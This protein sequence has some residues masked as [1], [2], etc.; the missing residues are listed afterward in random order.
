[1]IGRK[2]SALVFGVAFAV[3][4]IHL[5]QMREAP[6]FSVLMGDARGYDEWAQMIAGGQWLGTD[7]FYQAPL[8]PY[9]LG[10]IYAV[11]GRDLTLVRVI[12]AAVGAA[13]CTMLGLAASRL[14][15]RRVGLVAGLSLALYA[16]AIFFDALIQKTVLD[17][18]FLCLVL[19][20]SSRL[21]DS[22]AG[23]REWAWLGI[24]LG[25]FALTRE[26]ALVLAI[27]ILAW[28]WV[29]S[30]PV[31]A[32][33]RIA[34]AGAFALGL[35][36]VLAPVVARNYAVGGGFYVTTAQFGPN[37][38]IGN[39]ARADG[40]YAPLRPG[41]GAPEYERRDATDL[42]ERALGRALTPAQVS[43]YWT[44]RA[45]AFISSQPGRWVL[46]LGRKLFLLVNADEML[47]TESQETHAESSIVLRV[48][49]WFGHFG[50]LVPLALVGAVATWPER[51]R[52]W[53]VHAMA[54]AY[55]AS[56]IAFYVF[57]RYRFPLVPF[58][59]LFASAGLLAAPSLILATTLRQRA[60]LA[61][62]I[63][64]AAIVANWPALSS[65]M[66]R[67]ITETNLAAAL[68]ENG[69]IDEALVH[70]R[71]A[72]AIESGYAP[73]Y[74]NLG[75]ALRASGRVGEAIDAYE[76]SLQKL[77]DYPDAHYNLANALLEQGRSDEAAAHLRI[78]SRSLPTSAGVHN[79]LGKALAD[80]GWLEEAA[81]ELRQAVALE[82]GSATAHHNLGNVLA[83]QGQIEE[84]FTQLRRAME[85]EPAN[86]ETGYDLGTL[87]LEAGRIEEAVA[88]FEAVLRLRPLYAEAHNNLGIALASQG[89]VDQAMLHFERAVEINPQLAD[90]RRNLEMARRTR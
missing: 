56:V 70:Y 85:L 77:P 15:S 30:S 9:F 31:H 16:P 39:N 59:V 7:V 52:L 11:L 78:A 65:A 82:P 68:Q 41:R 62:A 80:K 74:N 19:W 13:A 3:R 26:N 10:V 1:M 29:P 63:A 48:L 14:F 71:R 6:V 45:L 53:P 67:A 83:S 86:A 58:L 90:A 12:Q 50:L 72:I 40:T 61:V 5:W 43:R 64:A 20:I 25:A 28:I 79:N 27:V 57:A 47:D 18:F 34:A 24:A 55:A 88:V 2:Q 84:A 23:T 4:L 36:L 66:M 33:P 17:V 51:R 54:I 87:L 73:A 46:L 32:R 37:F 35:A 60:V 49:G 75:T 8:Y 38:Y 44:D 42:A 69:R 76:R 22:A 21:C 81:V 89:K